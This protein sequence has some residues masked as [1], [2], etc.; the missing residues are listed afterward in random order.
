MKFSLGGKLAIDLGTAN[1]LVFVP[2]QGVVLN[3]PS[4]VAVSLIDNKVLAVGREAEA[5]LG[6]TPGNIRASRPMK[7]GVIA[8]FAV[9]EAMLKF[10]IKR[11]G[12]SGFMGPEV[13]VCAPSGVTQVERRA[14]L[15]AAKQAG[16]RKAYLLSEPLAAAIGAGIPID[17]PSGNMVLDM[18]GGTAETAIISLGGVVASGSVRV[19]GNRIDE[20]IARYIRRKHNLVIGE[21]TAERIKRQIGSA[22]VTNEKKILEITGRDSVSGLPR[23]VEVNSEEITQVIKEPLNLI[24]SMVK[25]V[26]EEVPPE[27]SSD[28]IDKGIVMSGGTATLAGLDRFLV[29]ETGVPVFVAEEPLLCVVK[30][31]GEV[32]CNLEKFRSSLTVV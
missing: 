4:V 9:T 7:D 14:V 26:L 10:F 12:V 20:A 1:S 22:M 18:G 31:A 13:L 21:A 27:L 8:D 6:R 3:E 2:G 24:A 15:A 25:T 28:I 19:A 29:H 5:M 23:Q 30:G 32:L 16:A 17:E 11:V